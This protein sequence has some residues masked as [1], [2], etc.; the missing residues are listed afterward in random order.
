[1]FLSLIESLISE[2]ESCI[3]V[4]CLIGKI[5]F[6]AVDAIPFETMNFGSHEN[7]HAVLSCDFFF[8]LKFTVVAVQFFDH[9]MELEK[10]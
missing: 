1:M 5:G 7:M 10:M 6:K 3:T 9:L 4:C 8:V 2:S